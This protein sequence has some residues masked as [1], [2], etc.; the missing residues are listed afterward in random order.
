MAGAIA[1]AIAL[2]LAACD[3]SALMPKEQVDFAKGVVMLVQNRDAEGLEAVAEP[4]LWQRLTPEVRERMARVFPREPVGSVSV[5][6][7]NSSFDSA[8][9]N[10][11]I[12]LVYRYARQDVQA[13]VSFRPAEHGFVLTAIDVLPGDAPPQRTDDSSR[14]S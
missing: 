4:A 11:T 7:Y 13:A 5:A 8:T 12:V 10:V 14:D 9:S 1:V 2:I 6:S 3:F